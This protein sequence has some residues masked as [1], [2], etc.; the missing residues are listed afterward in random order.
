MSSSAPPTTWN[1]WLR[2]FVE[3]FRQ[4]QPKS[5]TGDLLDFGGTDLRKSPEFLA[6][7]LDWVAQQSGAFP[8]LKSF[9]HR[10][11]HEMSAPRVPPYELPTQALFQ[12]DPQGY[13]NARYTYTYERTRYQLEREEYEHQTRRLEQFRNRFTPDLLGYIAFLSDLRPELQAFLDQLHRIP[14]AEHHRAKHSYLSAGTGSGKS[15]LTKHIVYHYLTENLGTSLIVLD[16]HG[17]MAQEIGRFPEASAKGLVYLSPSLFP[18]HSPTLNPLQLPSEMSFQERELHRDQ[19]MAAFEAILTDGSKLSDQMKTV[20]RPCVGAMLH[21][22]DS[23]LHDLL[24]M[25]DT[26]SKLAPAIIQR[27]IEASP[28][29]APFLHTHFLQNPRSYSDTKKSIFTR[30][31][32]LLGSSPFRNFL[33]GPTTFSLEQAMREKKIIIFDL[34][35]PIGNPTESPFNAI[36]RFILAHV[37]GIVMRNRLPAFLNQPLPPCHFF[38]DEADNYCL[39]TIITILKEARKYGLHLTLINQ[40]PKNFP[41]PLVGSNVRTN[42]AIKLIGKPAKHTLKE[43]ATLTETSTGTLRELSTGVFLVECDTLPGFL[44][45]VPSRLVD[46]RHGVSDREW[47]AIKE[48]QRN[49]YYRPVTL[50]SPAVSEPAPR[51]R[52]S[53]GKPPVSTPSIRPSRPIV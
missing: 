32:G 37:L 4:S 28:E 14:I 13:A 48:E 38:I 52:S 49:L 7:F 51:H 20:L 24:L 29:D 44:V 16:P 27:A 17:K 10:F 35:D 47:D 50:V 3:Q 22:P 1:Q 46:N 5:L 43:I 25:V 36:G 6:T 8:D 2:R 45:E 26:E 31:L 9:L 18:E 11:K 42:T 23:S 30:L 39:P 41:D 12:S 15:E 33:C 34:Q 40:A 19:L 53:S 21:L